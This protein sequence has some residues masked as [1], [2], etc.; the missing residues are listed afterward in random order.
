[1]SKMLHAATKPYNERPYRPCVGIFLLN[2]GGQV[3]AGRRIDSR[4]EAWQM[5]QGGIDH[6]VRRVDVVPLNKGSAQ[7]HIQL[8]TRLCGCH[9]PR[10]GPEH[11]RRT[12]RPAAECVGTAL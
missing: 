11:R 3:F 6:G 4:A 8:D 7:L 5:P 1:M 10:L 12:G 2:E 9:N